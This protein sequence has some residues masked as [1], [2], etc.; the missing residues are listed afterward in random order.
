ML[1]R[2]LVAIVASCILA[3]P[4]FAWK[5]TTHAYLASQAV[6]DAL[7][8]GEV[9]IGVLD[10][11]D[12]LTFA[13]A[14]ET[15]EALRNAMPQYRAG[16]L[17]PD[18][19]PDL[20]TGQ[21]VIHPDEAMSGVASGS[22]AWLHHVWSNFGDSTE[23]HAFRLGFLTH[24]AGDVFG[25]SFVNYFTGGPFEIVPPDNAIKHIVLEGYID[26][27]LPSDQLG[28]DFFN[29]SIAG[30]EGKIYSAMI[31]ARPG[32]AL[33]ALLPEG[34]TSTSF[35]VP[36]VFSTLRTSVVAGIARSEAE[37]QRLEQEA[38]DCGLFD[39]T[40]SALLLEAESEI[41]ELKLEY[42]QHWL[43][44]IDVG[45]AAWP[46]VSHRVAVALFFNPER[47]TKADEAQS[48]LSDYV[49]D[50]MISM[51]GAPDAVG[52]IIDAVG[53]IIDAITPD[54][55][56][57]PIRR[58]RDEAIDAMLKEAFGMDR[59]QLEAYLTQPDHYFDE[60]MS[61]GAGETVTLAEF[62]SDY[63]GIDDAGYEDPEL[64]FD[65]EFVPAAYNTVVLSKLILLS[66]DSINSLIS[67]LGGSATL[68]EPN[69]MLGFA[70]TL[71]GSN[72]WS[73]GLVLADDCKVYAKVFKML[74]G[75]SGC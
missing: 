15:L 24:A 54:F 67:Q 45:L 19:Y 36:R 1:H 18:A 22:D 44:D 11:G 60:V 14:P 62:N 72:Q 48:I 8:D 27:R 29:A 31:D 34:Q 12:L 40:C 33:D 6:D 16:V 30:L 69:V 3:G 47:A 68:G 5:P 46:D 70:H 56:L 13:V 21:Q 61:V 25:H 65:Y 20:L 9:S 73:E 42:K 66:P 64:A 32:S 51:A 57:E 7:D 17:G 52:A 74:P 38:D 2:Y 71:D 10:S 23:E 55:L 41:E 59:A 75:Q 28:G 49:T 53:D 43:E 58:L 35:S 37:I 63:L 4:A 26:K 39:P 50:H